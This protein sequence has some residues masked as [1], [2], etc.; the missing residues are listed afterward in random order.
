MANKDRPRGFQPQGTPLRLTKYE[1]GAAIYPGDAVALS[2]DGQIDPATSAASPILG[3][4]LTYAAAAGEDVMVADHPDQRFVVQ[5]DGS[6]VDAQT[7]I[8]NNCLILDTAGDATYR[9]S[10][11]ELDSSTISA[12]STTSAAYPLR[13]LKIDERPDNAL[14]AQADVVVA[15]NNH[16]LG[17][18]RDGI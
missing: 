12:V 7:D 10:R 11:Q 18:N 17:Q 8:G 16:Q 5:A 13:I 15:V 14:G 2:D 9:V 6:D 4:A 1:S 3:V